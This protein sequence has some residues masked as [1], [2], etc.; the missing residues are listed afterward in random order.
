MVHAFDAT[1]CCGEAGCSQNLRVPLDAVQIAYQTDD[2]TNAALAHSAQFGSGPFFVYEHI[3]LSAVTHK[4]RPALLDHSSAYGQWGN[5]MVELVTFHEAW[6]ASLS[7]QLAVG[8]K[9]LHHVAC[10]VEDLAWDLEAML[11]AGD[12]LVVEAVTSSG[13][14]FAFVSGGDRGHLVE[15]YEPS[16]RLSS[17]YALVRSAAHGWDGSEPV[18]PLPSR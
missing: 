8:G 17:L 13:L 6:P 16:P 18:R 11:G 1:G 9:G 12:E 2:V 4:G 10:F 7:D 14:R 3:N 5:V 15:L